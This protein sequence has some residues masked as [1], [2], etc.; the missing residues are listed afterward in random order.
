[1]SGQQVNMEKSSIHFAKGC[2]ERVRQDIMDVLDVHN[3]SLSEKYLGMPSDVGSS[4]NGAF[5]YL[6]D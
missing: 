4:V 1:V 3:V 2:Q 6:R 5:K